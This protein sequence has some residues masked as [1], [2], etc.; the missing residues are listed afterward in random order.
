MYTHPGLC[1]GFEEMVQVV[2]MTC[3]DMLNE[4]AI[5]C[6]RIDLTSIQSDTCTFSDVHVCGI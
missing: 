1:F 5:S 6:S 2:L 4:G 3:V